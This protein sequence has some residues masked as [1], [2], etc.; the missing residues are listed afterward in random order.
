MADLIDKITGGIDKGIK[1]IS[2]KSRDF[3][4]TSKLK[5]EIKDAEVAL[6]NKFKALGKKVYEMVNKYSLSEEALRVD[7]AGISVLFRKITELEETIKKIE[8]E[9]VKE[10]YGAGV[11]PC[12][13]CGSPNKSDAKFCMNC[14][15]AMAVEMKPEGKV[16]TTCG[17]SVKEGAK[18]CMRCGVKIRVE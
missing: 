8:L 2:S 4:E 10:Q 17:A 15:S 5:V 3:I 1:T 6:Q 7:C 18:F 14:G 9:A 12:A 16:C 13:K 11:I